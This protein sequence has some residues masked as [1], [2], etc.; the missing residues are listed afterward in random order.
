MEFPD[1][2]YVDQGDAAE[3]GT[4]LIRPS[5]V[6]VDVPAGSAKQSIRVSRLD[7]NAAA[8]ILGGAGGSDGTPPV[9][10]EW[11]PKAC[12]DEGQ[13]MSFVGNTVTR[14]RRSS[15]DYYVAVSKESFGQGDKLK[16]R[17]IAHKRSGNM[18]MGLG[19]KDG[20][21][22][23]EGFQQ[24]KL[25][26]R[27]WYV[28]YA[29]E[30]RSGNNEFY[31]G[32]GQV[33]S[34]SEVTIQMDAT[35]SPWTIQFFI[36][37]N[38]VGAA[39]DMLLADPAS[40]RLHLCIV[41]DDEGEQVEIAEID[42]Q[43]SSRS[44]RSA[45]GGSAQATPIT[46]GTPVVRGPGWLSPDNNE[47]GGAGNIGYVVRTTPPLEPSIPGRAEVWWRGTPAGSTRPYPHCLHNEETILAACQFPQVWRSST[48]NAAA[49]AAALPIFSKPSLDSEQVGAHSATDVV[50]RAVKFQA[51]TG[52]ADLSKAVVTLMSCAKFG[53]PVVADTDGGLFIN[54]PATQKAQELATASSSSEFLTMFRQWASYPGLF[55]E[56]RLRGTPFKVPDGADAPANPDEVKRPAFPFRA[57]TRSY[58]Y[59]STPVVVTAG[60]LHVVNFDGKTYA[61]Y[62][63]EGATRMFA[64]ADAHVH[65]RGLFL[66]VLDTATESWA[67]GDATADVTAAE[68]SSAT[69][70][71]TRKNANMCFRFATSALAQSAH[72]ALSTAGG[73]V[74]C[75]YVDT[76]KRAA[77]DTHVWLQIGQDAWICA[78]AADASSSL[79]YEPTP[80][81]L[82]VFSPLWC[83]GAAVCDDGAVVR[84]QKV[85]KDSFVAQ[86]TALHKAAT[87]L[88]TNFAEAVEALSEYPDLVA[89][90]WSVANRVPPPEEDPDTATGGLGT[91]S[92]AEIEALVKTRV[93]NERNDLYAAI[94][95]Q[96]GLPEDPVTVAR[97]SSE[98]PSAIARVLRDAHADATPEVLFGRVYVA[99]VLSEVDVVPPRL[100]VRRVYHHQVMRYV[101]LA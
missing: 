61:I 44:N 100:M 80:R 1:K 63:M 59:E 51:K 66:Y 67:D 22:L 83:G 91:P 56:M 46:C 39:V 99:V 47:D 3:A 97:A 90:A 68:A 13:G 11:D 87:T 79:S 74:S 38:E 25:V 23:D 92:R 62:D 82:P 37:G 18:Y 20:L 96:F 49:A 73:A 70:S 6:H 19:L 89:F 88:T 41:L 7:A 33:D 53:T 29:G 17:F 31:D 30:V 16:L 57:K 85:E 78:N 54:E 42:L 21:D 75:A 10:L 93:D 8:A 77:E 27:M 12:Y 26:N 40:A 72:L 98:E 2:L 36:N 65:R 81:R 69:Q 34:G 45:V 86:A 58:E 64:A 55:G 35:K 14:T 15:P 28:R 84:A 76:I 43:R 5:T 95:A 50:V 101:F 4:K 71:V 24:S 52:D 94:A 9:S 32:R 60:T 48:A